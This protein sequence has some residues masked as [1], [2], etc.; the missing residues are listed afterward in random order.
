METS[1]GARFLE[2][3]EHQEESVWRGNEQYQQWRPVP[4]PEPN[5]GTNCCKNMTSQISKKNITGHKK[6]APPPPLLSSNNDRV[7]TS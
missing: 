4:P 6:V 2:N 3:K 5:P 7:S 1:E